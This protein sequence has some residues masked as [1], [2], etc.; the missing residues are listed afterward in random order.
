[1]DQVYLSGSFDG[2]TKRH[3]LMFDCK[4]K[5]YKCT[6][7]LDKRTRFYYKF[8]VNGKWWVSPRESVV[9]DELGNVN[10]VHYG[11]DAIGGVDAH[12]LDGRFCVVSTGS[13]D[14]W[15][16]TQLS[17][18]AT[19]H[20]EYSILEL[21]HANGDANVISKGDESISSLG[22]TTINSYNV[23]ESKSSTDVCPSVVRHPSITSHTLLGR[24][25]NMFS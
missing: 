22:G 20:S 24:I 19:H 23:E 21:A 2:W 6:L 10:N 17:P 7:H 3:V 13:D 25:R 9:Q 8:V 11:E 12:G 5:V 18:V 16:F 1:M 14:T 15:S 4:D